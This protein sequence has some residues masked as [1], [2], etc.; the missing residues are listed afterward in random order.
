MPKPT[1]GKYSLKPYECTECGRKAN[2]GTNH[3]GQVYPYCPHCRTITVHKCLEP[4]P[5]GMGKPAPWQ[6][7][8]L[9]DLVEIR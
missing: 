2:H 8:K 5:E 1:T 6:I 3:W 4:V 7:C 9:D